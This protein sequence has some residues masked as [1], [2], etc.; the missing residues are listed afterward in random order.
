MARKSEK[1]QSERELPESIQIAGL[2]EFYYDQ[3]VVEA[4]LK[5]RSIRAE[6]QSLLQAMLYKRLEPK[7]MMLAELARKR[8][9]TVEQLTDDILTGKAQP[10]SPE[11]YA[12]FKDDG[13]EG[14]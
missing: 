9:I 7:K 3:I 12:A 11:Q 13:S 6:A 5:G 1:P 2:S 4:W 10:L 8:G 14:E